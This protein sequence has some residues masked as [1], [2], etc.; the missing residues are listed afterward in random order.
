MDKDLPYYV[1][2]SNKGYELPITKGMLDFTIDLLRTNRRVDKGLPP[3]EMISRTF[4][5]P[6]M[7]DGSRARAKVVEQN[8]I[9]DE[10][11]V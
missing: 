5:M 6:P 8:E 3:E 4:L 2:P 7:E 9:I 11:E 1:E 10:E